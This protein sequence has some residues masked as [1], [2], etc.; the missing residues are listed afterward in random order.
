MKKNIIVLFLFVVFSGMAQE[1]EQCRLF[2]DRDLYT[3]G[4]TILFKLFVPEETSSNVIKIDLIDTN[5]KI[6]S[7][8]NREIKD[9]QAHGFLLLP[10][11]LRTGSYLL[12]AST[13][14]NGETTVNELF[15]CNRFTGLVETPVISIVQPSKLLNEYLA[16]G[17][18]IDG[19]KQTYHK[20]EIAKSLLRLSPEL[21]T[22]IKEP[23]FV[24]VAEIVPEFIGRSFLID[25]NPK[26]DR[27]SG[28]GGIVLDGIATN[29]NTG[30]PFENATI[31]MS[32][33]D[34]IPRLDYYI[35][36]K[37][38]YFSFQLK[39]YYGKIP[40]IIQGFDPGKKQLLKIRLNRTDS[41]NNLVPTFVTKAVTDAFRRIA[42]DAMET[43]ML[44]K[45]YN[46]QEHLINTP[47]VSIKSNEYPFYG[48][49]TEVVYPS[50]FIDLNDFTEISRELLPGVKF[51]AI[52]R[53][54][55]LNILNPATLNYFSDQ[56]LVV[57]DGIPVFDLNV[58]K[59]LGSEEIQRIE[60]CRKER[61]Y[62]DLVFAGVVAIFTKQPDYTRLRNSDDLI[63]LEMNA[64]QPDLALIHN[65][66]LKLNE[67]DLRKVLL[68][69]PNLK[70]GE[71]IEVN[72]VTSDVHGEYR[73]IVR[74][75]TKNGSIIYKE[76][77]FSVK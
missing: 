48:I 15:V 12:C 53:I 63:K 47:P 35:T 6:I 59:N 70:S 51:R 67:P 50:L 33:P 7:A 19:L 73:L 22:Q 32:V 3:S 34:S 28:N 68:W 54:P 69:N 10:D 65:S 37:D 43:T 27:S 45:I 57:L 9:H 71:D 4:E 26:D 29:A 52:N 11:S 13:Q 76:Q 16:D 60:I 2:T 55:T 21:L 77:T 5:G 75:K 40:V 66:D 18:K 41:L 61:F 49:A 46:S 38:G 42:S 8:V 74:G 25:A 20:R 14:K 44:R 36:G 24:T 23:L 58:I 17:M 1:K 39:N 62:G 64:M 30:V 31:F 56:P 72:F